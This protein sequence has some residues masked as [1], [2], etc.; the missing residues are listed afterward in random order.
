MGRDEG[1]KSG[2]P[3]NYLPFVGRV[4]G[5]GRTYEE[6]G[7]EDR[8]ADTG[9]LFNVTNG[10]YT[11]QSV[12]ERGGGLPLLYHNP[13]PPLP[14]WNLSAAQDKRGEIPSVGSSV[15]QTVIHQPVI[16]Q[17]VSYQ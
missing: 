13:P 1:G 17:S 16:S 6:G 10:L 12:T 14:S 8:R 15:S 5:N 11:H 2:K 7:G 3:G 4:S 9:E